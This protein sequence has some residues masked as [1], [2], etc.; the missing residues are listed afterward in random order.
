MLIPDLTGIL[1]NPQHWESRA[2]LSAQAASSLAQ[3]VQGLRL[4]LCESASCPVYISS[5]CCAIPK[6]K[7]PHLQLECLRLVYTLVYPR[8]PCKDML[9]ELNEL[10]C[11]LNCGTIIDTD[12]AVP[13]LCVVVRHWWQSA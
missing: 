6:K 4:L 7:D 13:V 2:A 5:T 11:I 1:A 10:A 9:D 8:K 12:A 3:A